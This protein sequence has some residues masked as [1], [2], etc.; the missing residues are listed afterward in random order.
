MLIK[1]P[2][3]PSITFLLCVMWVCACGSCDS[4]DA[5]DPVV[6]DRY[7]QGLDD[8]GLDDQ[9]LDDQ[10]LDDQGLDD[11]GLDEPPLSSYRLGDSQ[12]MLKIELEPTFTLSWVRGDETLLTFDQEGIQVAWVEEKRSNLSYDPY[13]KLLDT[14]AVISPINVDW[15]S[16]SEASVVDTKD[17]ELTLLLR[18]NN[19]YQ[20]WMRWRWEESGRVKCDLITDA[21]REGDRR[22][23]P[24]AAYFVIQ[25][26]IDSQEG[27]YGLG[28]VYDAVN[29][30]GYLKAMQLE[31]D[32]ELEERYNEV[33]APIPYAVGS[34]GWGLFVPSDSPAAFDM[35]K[36]D[37]ERL[38]AHFGGGRWG[39]GGPLLDLEEWMTLSH[40][41]ER[42]EEG[43]SRIQGISFYLFSEPNPLDLTRHYYEVSGWP[44]LP[45]PW[46]LGPWIWRDENDDQAQVVSDLNTIRDLDLPTSGYWI[47]RPYESEIGLFDFNPITFLNPQELSQ[48]F[49]ANGFKLALWHAPYIDAEASDAAEQHRY[50]QEQ[51]FL[52]VMRGLLLNPWGAPIDF[53]HPDAMSWWR[54]QLTAYSDIGVEGYKL[55]YAEDVVIGVNGQRLPWVFH[56]GSDELTMH[57]HYQRL[58]HQTYSETLGE[59][60]GFLICRTARWGDQVNVNVM[61]PADLDA[62]FSRYRERRRDE[63]G[64]EYGPIGG[65]PAALVAGLSLS[66][67]GF[68]FFA[69]DT[70]GYRRSPP[71]K[72]TFMRWLELS[73][74]GT[75]M[76]TGTN[77]NDVPWEFNDEN[78]FDEEVLDTY[79]RYALLNIRLFP[80][81]WT[82][83][84]ELT[85]NGRAIQRTFGLSYP[86]MN[87]HPSDHFFL[88]D[89]LLVSPSVVRG[90]RQKEILI[91]PGQWVDWW[92][93]EVIDGGESGTSINREVPLDL[94]PM[95]VKRGALIPLLR[96]SID[97]LSPVGVN[98]PAAEREIESFADTPGELWVRGYGI[99]EEG[100]P[101]IWTLYDETRLNY[102]ARGLSDE[103]G[104]VF[105]Q[106]R[107]YELRGWD[108]APRELTLNG[109]ELP[110]A[111][112]QRE[113]LAL[114]QSAWYNPETQTLWIHHQEQAAQIEWII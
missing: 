47:D 98:V 7:D 112:D 56:D 82:Y 9:G 22:S 101:F 46:A 51:G 21:R 32:L 66:V 87:Q 1:R 3:R 83:A 65:V 52:P 61:W 33:H 58:Y 19:G 84:Q 18:L 20:L 85:R 67:S 108:Q 30:R 103:S 107:V 41:A 100:S 104:E 6:D 76:Q 13:P 53:T 37:S 2:Q 114:P 8:Q 28:E 44:K 48:T 31:L 38:S 57:A 59:D 5:R 55:D 12:G 70:G 80:Y 4:E 27:L 11:Q 92:T 29:Q 86:M 16:I 96:P 109:R 64:E 71:D 81:K 24:Y 36:R 91:P 23:H 102:T 79:R 45:A 39:S 17:N 15:T 54:E 78:G 50:A 88:G 89:S 105:T 62:D 99:P 26:L 69:S 25:P 74:L 90:E 97:T 73:A 95:Y 111:E 75:V 49:D 10:G 63:D 94:L 60:G 35:G 72:E 113:M 93:N 106:G 110:F 43:R 40:Q 68:P 77:S 34:R 42:S 14:E